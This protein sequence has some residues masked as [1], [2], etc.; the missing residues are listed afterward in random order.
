M[1]VAIDSWWGAGSDTLAAPGAD[2]T[3]GTMEMERLH[4]LFQKAPGFMAVLRG[5][6][7]IFEIVNH[8]CMDFLDQ[9][10]VLGAKLADA[11]PE[12][13]EQGFVTLL[14]EVYRTGEPYIG[15]DHRFELKM[16]G[17]SKPTVSFIDFVYQPIFHPQGG[18][19]AGIFV[20]G[21][22]VTE[23]HNVRQAMVDAASRKDQFI[24]TLAHELRNPLAPIRMAARLLQAPL[25]SPDVIAITAP[26]IMR[27]V[28]HMT[29]MLDSLLDIARIAN[30][31]VLLVKE[32]L[33]SDRLVAMAMETAAP[34][35]EAKQHR[36]T[37]THHDGAVALNGDPMRLAQ[38]LT[39]VINNAA[40][41]SDPRGRIRIDTR[42]DGEHL[43]ITVEDDGIG[44]T[45]AAQ[46]R[47]FDM[48]V[49]EHGA[50]AR[51]QGGLGIGLALARSLVD[52][53]DGSMSV[54]SHGLGQGSVFTIRLPRLTRA[55]GPGP[56][57]DGVPA[58][59][60]G[61]RILLVDDNTD[62]DG[63]LAR[64]LT[65]D[66]HRVTCAADAV[67]AI[68]AARFERPEVAIL[69]L[70]LAGID[71]FRLARALRIQSWGRDMLLVAVAG[72]EGDEEMGRA[73][74]AGFDHYLSTP[75]KL[76]QLDVLMRGMKTRQGER[77]L[78]LD[79]E[80]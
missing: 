11:V 77:W 20:Q 56:R 46:E 72:R 22:V 14:D 76:D 74:R 8:A 17:A 23:E 75:V 62:L 2:D 27:Q 80:L 21:H 42:R 50:L 58:A 64:C 10:P 19:A 57:I 67:A 16:G 63:M 30:G 52:L 60:Q 71:G 18:A 68:E 49:Q 26:I 51:A 34:Q 55:G 13:A 59:G 6:G 79:P 31:Q 78:G 65:L 69:D 48:F 24:A 3:N 73:M 47:I 25:L 43:L 4:F 45:P 38:V 37:V 40:K 41:Y 7:H 32:P 5:P 28:E 1:H 33:L 9:R 36:L 15:K 66:G 53:H 29:R 39:N 54:H 61:R 70:G 12:A 35:V 44:L